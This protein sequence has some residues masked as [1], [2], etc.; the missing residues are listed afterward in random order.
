MPD[1]APAPRTYYLVD[2]SGY[3]FRAFHALPMM[4]RRSDGTPVNAVF[5]FVTMLIRLLAEI[6]AD[7]LAVVFDAARRN[8]RNDIYP[9]Y[10]ANRVE[11]PPELIPQ[12]PLIR[13]A[14]AAFALPCVEAEGYEADDLIATYA[15]LAR[16]RGDRTVI[17]SSDKDLMQLVG[18]RVSMLDPIKNLPIGPA[19][20]IGKFGVPPSQVVDVQALAGDSTDNVP[21]VPGIGIKTAAQ[22]IGA[23]GD[24]DAVLARTDEIKQ[25]KRRQSLIDFAEQARISRRLVRLD[26]HAPVPLALDDLVVRPPDKARLLAFLRAQEFRSIAARIEAQPLDSAALAPGT[27]PPAAAEP[28]S[29]PLPAPGAGI[30]AEAAYELIQTEAALTAWIDRAQAAGVVAVDTETDSLDAAACRLVGVSLSTAPGNGC[31][32]P[33]GHVGSAGAGTL[34]LDAADAAPEQIPLD[35]AIALLRPLFE[36]PAVLKVGHNI[37]YDH[38]VL[39]RHGAR[40]APVDDTMLLSYVLDGGSR[41]H[42]MDELAE[43]HLGHT[44]ITFEEVCGKG[45]DRITFDR[46][47]LDRAL[48]YAAEDADITLRLWHA[49]RSRLLAERMVT[50]YETIE[51]PLPPIVADMERTGIKVDRDALVRLSAEFAEALKRL[52]A[53]IHR[54]AGHPFN[55]GSPKQ[56]GEVLFDE[57]SLPG[58]RKGKT[59]AY[60]TDVAV[61]EPLAAQGHDIVARV[62][63]WRQ[64]A[65]L[66]ST[67]TDALVTQ[68]NP[69][70]GRVHTSYSLAATSTGRMASNEPN[71]QN[72]PIRTSEGRRIR[73]AFIAEPGH[74]LISVDYSQIE[75]RLVAEIAGI[76]VLKQAF[77]DG[78]DIHA[79]TA[80][81]V[82]GVALDRVTPELR[83][84]AKTINFGIIYGISGFGLAA[85]L[86]IPQGE[87]S[88]FIRS[89]LERFPELRV[90]MDGIKAFAREHGY[91]VTRFGRRCHVPGIK[92]PNPARRAGAERQA[93]NAPIQGTA[94]DII[95]RAMARIPAALDRAGLGRSRMLLQVHDELVFEAPEDAAER[96]GAV[97]RR[98]MERA[99]LLGVPLVA[100]VGSGRNWDEAH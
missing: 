8:F 9:D 56:L 62:L 1:A 46:V 26:D 36:D 68:I 45:K 89:Y 4:T 59:G 18:D 48:A 52:E 91:V 93:I 65:K 81:Q 47:P 25:P 54:L 57:M 40:V 14:A 13:D 69:E 51:R 58:G 38:C 16:E 84:R 95:K 83:R 42:G 43:A 67:Y 23:F 90:W 96:T 2:G 61:L 10:K 37:K 87:A 19:E 80:S 79:M 75:L 76:E 100:E 78:I 98:E 28:E 17:V 70:T 31:Y 55:V 88:A 49:L 12:F 33:L 30:P 85:Q 72:I 64:L 3:I 24:L 53:E 71:L 82:F 60:S 5:G 92:D 39:A 50:V 41:G 27:V 15:R 73:Q 32:I 34:G 63:D 97:V 35:R 94:A 20:V 74:V 21:G 29:G 6:R 44:T 99:A 77:R 7:H 66:K 22:L 86:G 11:T